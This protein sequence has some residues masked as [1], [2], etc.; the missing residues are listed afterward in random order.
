MIPGQQFLTTYKNKL[1]A[2]A[3]KDAKG[4]PLL[5][6]EP[7]IAYQTGINQP[8][9]SPHPGVAY[10]VNQQQVSVPPNTQEALQA[11]INW[12]RLQQDKGKLGMSG[13]QQQIMQVLSKEN[14][15]K[16]YG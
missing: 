2:A 9:V 7:G 1:L 15:Q 13:N 14:N 5:Q 16:I 12:S 11:A 3:G 8:K 4:R 10:V 6:K